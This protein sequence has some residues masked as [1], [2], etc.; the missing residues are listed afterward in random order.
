VLEDE[1][2]WGATEWGMGY[3]GAILTGG[4]P[5]QAP[6]HTDGICCNTS[7]WLDGKQIWDQGRAVHPE[8]AELA[9]KLGKT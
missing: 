1:R 6:S 4:E 8:L 2:F 7:V 3:V 9:K 5:I